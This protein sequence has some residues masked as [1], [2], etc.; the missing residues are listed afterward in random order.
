MLN[1]TRRELLLAKSRQIHYGS[2]LSREQRQL[3]ASSMSDTSPVIEVCV[4]GIDGLVA[5]QQAGADRVEL[6]ASLIEGGIT[7]S[8]GNSEGSPSSGDGAI[9]C[10]RQAARRRLS[11]F[12][13]RAR[14]DAG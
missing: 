9:P 3:E 11:L 8:L 1:R 4:E 7:P 5:A 2:G 12:G 10:D 13:S 6:C 14:L